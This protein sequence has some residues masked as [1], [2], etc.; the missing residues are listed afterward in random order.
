V[1]TAIGMVLMLFP[2]LAIGAGAVW[3]AIA[4][5]TRK[6]SLASLV[7]TVLLPLGIAASRRPI[8]EVT[9][10]AGVA[11]LVVLR[12]A[13]NIERLVRGDERSLPT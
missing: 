12:H 3:A 11:L 13:S 5:V 1:A 6:A 7:V 9:I 2:V 8:I 10:V 4:V